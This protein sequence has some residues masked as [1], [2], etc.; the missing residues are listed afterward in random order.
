MADYEIKDFA[1]EVAYC[2]TYHI[3]Q[4]YPAA[5]EACPKSFLLSVRGCTKNAIISGCAIHKL[6]LMADEAQEAARQLL[7]GNHA[8]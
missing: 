7:E 4:M 6:R 1:D 2:V 5:V 3:E 8:K